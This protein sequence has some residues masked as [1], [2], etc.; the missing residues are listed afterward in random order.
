MSEAS[1]GGGRA[2]ME[3]WIV[4]KSIEDDAFRQRLLE[5]PKET[6]EGGARDAAARRGAGGG[7]GGDGRHH[8][9]GA[10]QHP[11]GGR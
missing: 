7:R 2:E 1:G 9:P 10:S 8:L 6:L 3:R 4:Q 5:D 11:D